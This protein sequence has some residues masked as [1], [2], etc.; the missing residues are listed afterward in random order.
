M[1]VLRR[2]NIESRWFPHR[3]D[4][5]IISMFTILYFICRREDDLFPRNI[6]A[7]HPILIFCHINRFQKEKPGLARFLMPR[8]TCTNRGGIIIIFIT[9]TA[10]LSLFSNEGYPGLE[11]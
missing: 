1:K 2:F 6:C 4:C 5:E 8:L 10:Y 9:Y 11:L 3:D 7:K